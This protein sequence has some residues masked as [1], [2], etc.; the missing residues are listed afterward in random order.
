MGV[1]ERRVFE[2]HH[3]ENVRVGLRCPIFQSSG[4][5]RSCIPRGCRMYAWLQII[6]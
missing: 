6:R 4:A 2:S 3:I 5:Q 1:K